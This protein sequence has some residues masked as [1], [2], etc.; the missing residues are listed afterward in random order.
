MMQ[1]YQFASA[2]DIGTSGKRAARS[3]FEEA[4]PSKRRRNDRSALEKD[5]LAA[6]RLTAA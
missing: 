5:K 6:S 2:S 3:P 4:K 1:V